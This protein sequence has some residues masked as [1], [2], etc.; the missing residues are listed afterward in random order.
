MTRAPTKRPRFLRIFLGAL[1]LLGLAAVVGARWNIREGRSF[2]ADAISRAA[3]SPGMKIE[4]GAFEDPLSARPLLRDI[5]IADD[6]GV[7]LTIDH[8]ALGWS[9]LALFAL[10]VDVERFEIGHIA[11]TRRPA[12]GP[13]AAAPKSGGGGFSIPQ[14][15]VRIKL[16]RL[17]LERIA[18]AEP[19]L[20]AAA[21]FSVSGDAALRS[22]A[23]RFSLEVRRLDAPGEIIAKGELTP[24]SKALRFSLTAREPEGGAIVRLAQIPDLPALD[25]A[26]T[27][28]GTL[29]D[30]SARLAAKAGETEANGAAQLRRAGAARR[31]DL[32]FSARVAPLLPPSVAIVFAGATRLDGAAT[33]SDDGSATVER[34][35][36]AAAALRIDATGSLGADGALAADLTVK[37]P[38]ASEEAQFRAKTLDAAIR[39]AGTLSRP[40]AQIHWLVEDARGPFGRIGHSDG[41]LSLAAAKKGDERFDLEG[42]AQGAGLSFVDRGLSEAIG[43]SFSFVLR[44][45]A[46]RAGDAEIDL[47][48]LTIGAA[49]AGF[50]GRVGPD[51]VD[52]KASLSAQSLARFSR[53]AGR[54]LR[55]ALTFSAV[56]KGAPKDGTLTA[57]LGGAVA[58][59][60]IGVAALDGL[61]GRR[62]ALTGVAGLTPGGGLRFDHLA[63]AADHLQ[64]TIDG[65]ATREAADI[66]AR[67]ALP[68]LH[69]ADARFSGRADVEAKILGSLDKPDARVVATLTDVR[70]AGRGIPKLTVESDARDL[71]GALDLS[72]TLQGTV[73]GAA[74][75]GGAHVAK[76]GEGWSVDRLDVAVGRAALKGA[77][78]LDAAGLAKGR[79]ALTAPDLDDFSVFALQKLA[80]SLDADI[81]LDGANGG[82]NI[83]IDA[84]GARIRA[85]DASIERLS[86]KIS[87]RD[88]LRRPALD[89]DAALDGAHVGGQTISKARLRASPSEGGSALDLTAEAMGA[90]LALRGVLTPGEPMRLDLRALSV[91]RGGKK[92]AL[93]APTTITLDKGVVELKDFALAAG[94]GRLRLKGRIG[95]RLDLTAEAR[96]LP[97]SIATM[98]DA[99]LSLDGALDADARVE[100][101]A[102]APGGEW[103]VKLAKLAAPQTRSNGLP[104]IDIA[105]HGALGGGRTTLDAD[106][107]LGSAGR[108]AIAGS[109]PLSATGGLDLAI[110]GAV[111]A[112]LADTALAAGG[113]TLRGKA[114][115]DLRVIG[116]AAAP[117]LAGSV[118]LREGAFAD[119]VNGV[120]LVHI[121]A[122]IEGKG[123]ELNIAQLTAQTRNGGRITVT[124]RVAVAPETG[125]PGAIHIMARNA[126]LVSSEIVTATSDLDLDIGGALARAPRV[127][128]RVRLASME[129]NVPDRLPASAI[130]PPGAT[131]I[132]PG[133]F[134]KRMIALEK[135]AKEKAGKKTSFDAAIDLAIA[136]PNRIFVRGRGIDAEFGGELRLTGTLQKP[137]ANGAFDL[138]RGRL[139]LLTQR[140]DIS[141]GRLTF[142]GGLVPQ[143]DFSAETTAGDVTATIGVSGPAALPSFAF[144]STPSLPQDE[145]LSRLLFAKASGSLSPFQAV[146]LAAALAQFSGAGTGVDAF[147]KMRRALGVDS[148]DLE[149]GGGEGP[150]VGASRY[151]SDRISVGVRTGMKP[152]QTAVGVGVDVTKNVRVKGETRVDGKSS[153]GV[154]VEWEY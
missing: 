80:G 117:Q 50:A 81:A 37:G 103:K 39:L 79:I 110:K 7:W 70:A 2:L 69:R 17:A 38:P 65:A 19:V 126:Q 137:V 119:P 73:D 18:L 151:I 27:G 94:A 77:L 59:P 72:A 123:R 10:E 114:N 144:S 33:F 16:G 25:V 4:I 129:V 61:L 113:Q 141:R 136:A 135:Q 66:V 30:L 98:A 40:S 51:V 99:S 112:K 9:P 95:E 107:A 41:D 116:A 87:G 46:T 53:F 5:S 24:G 120:A 13:A 102:A 45:R 52:G 44:G 89:G 34:M 115:I 43:D 111:D 76:A 71:L 101:P 78:A 93:A 147:E 29:D 11:V 122:R 14:L 55:G 74:A 139:Q 36:L 140:I 32:D 22:D 109:A 8:V 47:A 153:V 1:V 133:E 26:L 58:S 42:K 85:G 68:D 127:S 125:F 82:Q 128:G 96:A 138:R 83:R 134:A 149:A 91:E 152:E 67:I 148:L 132:A 48:T 75:Q 23:A 49:E 20:G 130:A 54:E 121:D 56:L 142:A 64:A 131:H 6:K 106:I 84:K 15:P 21:A 31:L 105:A 28:E 150:K 63:L 3:S 92:I 145:V 154:G 124:G 97:L 57:T 35:T 86:A 108:I 62:L 60:A 100:G 143:L 118:I 12:P 104:P 146:Q 90:A 88:L